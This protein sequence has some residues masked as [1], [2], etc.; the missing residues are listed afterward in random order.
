[1]KKIMATIFT[2]L[3]LLCVSFTFTG[4]DLFSDN[5]NKDDAEKFAQYYTESC[6]IQLSQNGSGVGSS[7]LDLSFS[8]Y[9]DKKI[10]AYEFVYILYDVYDAPLVYYFQKDKYNKLQVTPKYDFSPSKGDFRQYNIDSQVYYAEVYIYYVLFEDKTSWGF[11][12]NI[13]NET[14][15]KLATKYKI[16]RYAY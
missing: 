12:E 3:I 6:P 9:S 11:R 8:N 5:D 4:C 15:T 10:I 14:I 2:A 7:S 16:E 1:M 13:S